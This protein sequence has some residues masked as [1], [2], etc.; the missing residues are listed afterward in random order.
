MGKGRLLGGCSLCLLLLLLLPA[1]A[2]ATTPEPQ[3]LVLVPFLIHTETPEK[4]CVQLSH[5]NES[6]TLSI[7]LEYGLQNESLTREEVGEEEAF[8]CIS[9]QI[10]KRSGPPEA[11]LTVLVKG[12]TLHFWSRKRVLVKHLENLVFVQT[13]KPIYKPGQKVQFRIVSLS[14]DF[15]PVNEQFPLVYIKDPKRNRLAQ[16]RDVEL[17]VGLTQLSFPLTSEPAQGTYTVVVQTASGKNVEHSF[18][19]EEYV[20]PKFEVTIKAPKVITIEAQ[21]L[22]VTVC[23]VYTYGKPVPGQVNLHVCR[24]H[25][26]YGYG[27]C[28]GRNQEALCEDF[29][30][31]ADE[32]GCLTQGVKT[33]IFQLKRERYVMSLQLTGTVTEEGTGVEL[34]GTRNVGIT[35]TLSILEAEKLDAHYK[36]GLPLFGQVRLMDGNRVPLANQTIQVGAGPPGQSTNYITDAQGRVRFSIDTANLTGETI[37]FQAT[38]KFGA[39]CYDQNWISPV[40]QQLFRTIPR[41]YSPSKSYVGIQPVPGPLPCGRPQEVRVHYVLTPGVLEEKRL[42][43]AYLVLAKGG[44]MQAGTHILALEHEGEAKGVFSLDFAVGPDVAPLARLLVYAILPSGE[45]LAHSADI[46]VETCFQHK[47]TLRF[48]EPKALPGSQTGLHLS[49]S[50]GS[51]CAVH[52]VD[53]SVFLLKPEAEL[54]PRTVY[55]L[56]PVKNLHGYYYKSHNLDEPNPCLTLKNIVVDGFAYSPVPFRSGEADSYSVLKVRVILAPSPDFEASPVGDVEESTCLCRN[57]RKTVS[58]RL[59]P[60]SLGKVNITASAEAL[61]STELCG[62]EIVETPQQGRKDT[63]IKELLVE[64]EGEE[65]EAVFSSLLCAK[66]EA[67]SAPVSLKL[68]ENVVEGSA[69]ASFCVLVDSSS[70]SSQQ[71]RQSRDVEPETSRITAGTLETRQ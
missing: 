45:L 7:T 36:P 51:L 71:R 62:N 38:Y 5:L 28:Q 8:K 24:R 35:S 67:Q 26:D 57:G 46:T 12:P 17:Q 1:D 25:S 59:A 55:D 22:N 65:K 15:K 58:W 44:I 48:S 30:G 9:F 39:T 33:K 53:K 10:P 21:E 34:A 49:A 61:T 52:A 56:L 32:Q 13:D 27:S 3:Y 16:W 66:E 37:N 69:R 29:S 68:P 20:L 18:V 42:P 64:P 2:S 14:E 6:V 50:Q 11:L 41:F 54:S 60:K 47:V 19:V 40:H 31:Q 63:V 23:G 43:F 70:E 4:I